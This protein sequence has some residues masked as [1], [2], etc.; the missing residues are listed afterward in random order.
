MYILNTQNL[1]EYQKFSYSQKVKPSSLC[2][3]NKSFNWKNKKMN[4]PNNP[5]FSVFVLTFNR[6]GK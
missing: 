1:P 4:L 3:S 5:T 6:L 2:D